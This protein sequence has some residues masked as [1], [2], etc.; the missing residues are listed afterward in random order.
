MS[1]RI[2][3]FADVIRASY[4]TS[5]QRLLFSSLFGSNDSGL[6]ITGDGQDSGHEANL[7]EGS[8]FKLKGPRG[9]NP[10]I[11]PFPNRVNLK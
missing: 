11:I 2:A 5:L 6:P 1:L 8:L 3:S 7:H 9:D 4:P 10:T